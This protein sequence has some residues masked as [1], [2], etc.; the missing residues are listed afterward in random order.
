D[1][2]QDLAAYLSGHLGAGLTRGDLA[3][4]CALFLAHHRG[5]EASRLNAANAEARLAK[6]RFPARACAFVTA[7][8]RDVWRFPALPDRPSLDD[9]DS[10][11]ALYRYFQVTADAGVMTA[12]LSLA[13][14]LVNTAEPLSMEAWHAHLLRLRAVLI[15]YFRRRDEIVDPAP[16]LTGTDLLQIG[17]P[18]GPELGEALAS[19]R[20]AQ[21]AGEVQTE[22]EARA[23][24]SFTSPRR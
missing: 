1:F 14:T 22:A 18:Q 16:L 20:E 4:W 21:A 7:T 15:A 13:K 12:L 9:A 23:W 8:V 17:F 3:P 24:I 6:L 19:L 2:R 10:R 5:V 11:R